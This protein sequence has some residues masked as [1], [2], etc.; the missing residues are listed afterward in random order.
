MI[1]AASIAL[2]KRVLASPGFPSGV[3]AKMSVMG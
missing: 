2:F 3:A 1:D